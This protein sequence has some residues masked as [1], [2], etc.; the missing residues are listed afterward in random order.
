MEY[1]VIVEDER[2][3]PM[4]VQ[5]REGGPW[6]RLREE[7]D[8]GGTSTTFCGLRRRSI[9]PRT[10]LKDREWHDVMDLYR[11]MRCNRRSW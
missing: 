8:P 4:A 1:P 10:G 2:P 5:F 11:C 3:E 6:H 9:V 7:G